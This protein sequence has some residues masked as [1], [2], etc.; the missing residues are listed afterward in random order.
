MFVLS[1]SVDS[2]SFTNIVVLRFQVL[3]AVVVIYRSRFVEGVHFIFHLVAE[4]VLQLGGWSVDGFQVIS[5]EDS[6]QL[7]GCS[8]DVG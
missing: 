6:G 4:D 7:F 5:F 1:L 8:F 2:V 3:Q